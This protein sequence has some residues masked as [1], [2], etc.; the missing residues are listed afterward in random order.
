[1]SRNNEVRL[2]ARPHPSLSP[3]ERV[4]DIPHLNSGELIDSACRWY[5]PRRGER[6]PLLQG[7]K[8]GMRASVILDYIVPDE[9]QFNAGGISATLLTP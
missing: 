5:K 2:V 8:A 6:F 4:H 7:E 1:M 3:V 9:S